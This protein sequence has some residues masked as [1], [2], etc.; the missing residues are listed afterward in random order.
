M[1]GAALAEMRDKY[2]EAAPDDRDD[3]VPEDAAL[4]SLVLDERYRVDERIGR[5][6]MGIVYRASHVV[7]ERVVALKVLRRRYAEI[8]DVAQRF[9][10]EALLVSRIKHPNVVDILDYGVSPI[11]SP[12]FVMEYLSGRSLADEIDHAGALDPRRAVGLVMQALEGLSAAHEH[13]IVH[14]DL[15]PDNVFLVLTEGGGEQVKLL[16]FGI[17]RQEGRAHRLTAEGEIVGT[18][19]Y[20][21]PEQAQGSDVDGRSDIYG[22][23]IILFEMLTGAVPFRSDSVVGLLAKQVCDEP[24]LLRDIDAALANLAHTQR[25]LSACLAKAADDRPATAAEACTLF[26][27]ALAHDL[28][29]GNSLPSAPP[30]S[31]FPHGG[32][33]PTVAIGSY[34]V[35]ESA[36]SAG[37]FETHHAAGRRGPQMRDPTP[38]GGHGRRPPEF[39]RMS[40]GQGRA[41]AGPYISGGGAASLPGPVVVNA[42]L[43]S[44]YIPAQAP[45]RDLRLGGA[46]EESIGATWGEGQTGVRRKILS[47]LTLGG[48]AAVFAG[49]L[50]LGIVNWFQLR[51]PV[52]RP[53]PPRN[54]NVVPIA[55]P[56]AATSGDTRRR[57]PVAPVAQN[58]TQ[59]TDRG[60]DAPPLSASDPQEIPLAHEP[61][62][63]LLSSSGRVEVEAKAKTPL[64]R[65]V[66]RRRK[67]QRKKNLD[68]AVPSPKLQ[69]PDVTPDSERTE[70]KAATPAR[71][72]PPPTAPEVSTG[73]LKDPFQ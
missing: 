4:L 58:R 26:S 40:S 45:E 7:L 39:H 15:K 30:P 38:P 55:D 18:P 2:A 20:M 66:K 72:R 29:Q 10:Q 64:Q 54:A 6:G 73:D 53:Q 32:A 8:E 28:G 27:R 51:S 33:R 42:A 24:P 12:Y 49:V 22:I 48:A 50:T 11:G 41:L 14:R 60:A 57:A 61:P 21:S 31:H 35:V 71:R 46:N 9:A 25:V 59:N 44:R 68:P 23:G 19:E 1:D 70:A 63:R 3:V 56:K 36:E 13:R 52:D 62:D 47:F 16:D 17:A 34:S 65:R 67:R 5:G 37:A 69:S 43:P